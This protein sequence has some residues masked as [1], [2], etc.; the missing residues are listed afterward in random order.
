MDIQAT[1]KLLDQLQSERDELDRLVTE[2]R[3]LTLDGHQDG[4]SVRIGSDSRSIAVTGMDK[5]YAQCVIRGREMILL[6]IKKVYRAAIE[7]QKAKIHALELK[8][9]ESTHH[10]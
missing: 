9:R 1:R 3:T 7:Y 10:D 5:N 8:I 6:G 4:I 2:E